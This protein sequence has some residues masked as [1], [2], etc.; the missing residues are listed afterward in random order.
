MM[1]AARGESFAGC[2]SQSMNCE[3]VQNLF[4]AYL[5][6]ELSGP[7]A[8]EFGAHKLNCPSCRRE[9]ALLEVAGDVIAADVDAPPLG[10]EFTER[11]LACTSEVS[12]PWYRPRRW[13]LYLGPSLAAAACLAMMFFPLTGALAP[14]EQ[15]DAPVH[16]VAGVQAAPASPEEMLEM[17]ER[18]RKHHPSDPRLREMEDLFRAMIEGTIDG[19]NLLE[20]YGKETIMEILESIPIDVA[21][22]D[23]KAPSASK[24]SER[25]HDPAVE[26][27]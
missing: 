18:A 12:R 20:K 6:G 26:D 27:L 3:Q 14:K 23:P 24:T 10:E 21:E 11:L 22:Q 5:D 19:A 17:I 4:D 25:R 7:L 2:L 15:S 13:M 8:A 9:L 16:G 1:P